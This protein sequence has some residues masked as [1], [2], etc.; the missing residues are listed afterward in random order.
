MNTSLG[1]TILILALYVLAA[2]RVTR[3]INFDTV[4]DPLRLWIARRAQTAKRAQD[5]ASVAGQRVAAASAGR[6]MGRWNTLAS[7]LGCPWCVGFWISVGGAFVAVW[8]VQWQWWCVAPVALACSHLVG[9]MAPLSS[10]EDIEI[11]SD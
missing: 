3:L 8:L 9:V 6:R 7:F 10:D 5:E 4:L 1:H 11:V 2:A